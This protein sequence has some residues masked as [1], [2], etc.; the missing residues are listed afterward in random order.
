MKLEYNEKA[1]V[2][3]L[4]GQEI[5]AG[6]QLRAEIAPA[7]WKPCRLEYNA[8]KDRYYF[9]GIDNPHADPCAYNVEIDAQELTGAI[10]DR[11]GI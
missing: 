8:D 9:S 7:Y 4:E 10:F 2:F 1:D 3:T 5:R 6:Q 11:G